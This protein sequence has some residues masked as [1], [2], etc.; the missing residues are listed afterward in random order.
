MTINSFLEDTLNNQKIPESSKRE[1]QNDR[2]K[3]EL[4]INKISDLKKPTPYWG[5]SYGKNTMIK[6]SYDIDILLYYPADEPKS[7]VE[8]YFTVKTALENSGERV[9]Q[10]NVALRIEKREGYHIDIVP[11]KRYS[12]DE[13]YANI[14]RSKMDKLLKTSVRKQIEIVSNFGRRD[15]LKLMKLWKVRNN[16][17]I[18]SFLI[19]LISIQIIEDPSISKESAIKRILKFLSTKIETC[20][21][22]DPSNPNNNISADEITSSY[23]KSLCKRVATQCLDLDLDNIHGW[24]ELFRKKNQGENNNSNYNNRSKSRLSPDSP[25]TRFA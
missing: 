13:M 22:L 2:E 17:N 19:E 16:I 4:I 20:R 10:K 25:G 1:M 7:L 24:E 15:I 11:A 6:D 9:I 3:Y 18:P 14:Y 23:Q 5:G 12:T 8:I 21:I